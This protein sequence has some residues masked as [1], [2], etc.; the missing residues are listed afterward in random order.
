[1]RRIFGPLI[2]FIDHSGYFSTKADYKVH[3]THFTSETSGRP[4]V[5]LLTI[6]V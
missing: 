5:A 3:V 6:I 1:M 2:G 4:V